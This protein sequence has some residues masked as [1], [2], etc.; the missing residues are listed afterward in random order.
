MSDIV[1]DV[2]FSY[3]A[4]AQTVV[5]GLVVGVFIPLYFLN[6]GE[7]AKLGGVTYV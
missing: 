7:L 1:Q 6:P 4:N 3:G 5:F 2:L